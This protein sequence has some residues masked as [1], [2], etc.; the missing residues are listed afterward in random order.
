MGCDDF[1]D[2][3]WNITNEE[4]ILETVSTESPAP[5]RNHKIRGKPKAWTPAQWQ[6]TYR[7]PSS[8]NGYVSK[9]GDDG[10]RQKFRV[11]PS[12]KDRLKIDNNKN[13]R[14]TRLLWF[15][16]PILSLDK[17]TTCTITLMKAIYESYSAKQVCGRHHIINEVVHKEFAKIGSKKGCHPAPFIHHLYAPYG[18]LTTREKEEWTKKQPLEETEPYVDR[19]LIPEENEDSDREVI[20]LEG[21]PEPAQKSKK[22][23]NSEQSQAGPSRTRNT[24]IL[25]ANQGERRSIPGVGVG[26]RRRGRGA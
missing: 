2:V 9:K 16:V 6:A 13:D 21:G 25:R 10:L 23:K 3:E 1:F 12:G 20:D 19:E 5:F 18:V 17:P 14:E 15:L 11:R 4:V 22:T 8:N 7:F 24:S 26:G